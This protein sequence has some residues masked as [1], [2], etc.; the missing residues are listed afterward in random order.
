MIY[1]LTLASALAL[2]LA[3]AD[4]VVDADATTRWGFPS[5]NFGA[6][7]QLQV[8]STSKAFI[9][10]SLTPVPNGL[11]NQLLNATLQLY[12]NRVVT[13]GSVL[14]GTANGQWV[15][16]GVNEANAPGIVPLT[17]VFVTQAMGW[18]SVDVTSAVQG[19]LAGQVND[20]FVLTSGAAAV[21]FDAKESVST[22]Q[23]ARLVLTFMGPAGPKGDTGTKG[24]AGSP[25]AQGATGLTGLAGQNGQT[26]ATGPRGLTG[27][28]GPAS[29]AILLH[30]DRADYVV[31][32]NGR[33]TGVL[34]CPSSHP[35]I[36]SGGCGHRDSNSA[37]TD[38][39]INA[40]NPEGNGWRCIMSNS[41]SSS[42]SLFLFA[43]CTQ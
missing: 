42:R 5:Q 19:W 32:G 10:F 23:P 29:V 43:T 9:R 17:Q 36:V 11:A 6:L 34:S 8:D 33:M 25:G 39:T 22:S 18:V 21:L 1:K 26:G 2:S 20:G 35:Y 30:T 37:A 28:A 40:S 12:V 41:S 24:A 31:A 15:E 27:E 13:P 16:P 38:I 3:A 4:L 14:V 7:P